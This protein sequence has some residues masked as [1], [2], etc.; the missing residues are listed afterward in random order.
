MWKA[1]CSTDSVQR[2][3]GHNEWK[4]ES[5]T[6]QRSGLL[7]LDSDLDVTV[8]RIAVGTA[9]QGPSGARREPAADQEMFIPECLHDRTKPAA[10]V[11]DFWS[12]PGKQCHQSAGTGGGAEKMRQCVGPLRE[13]DGFDS[14]LIQQ[15]PALENIHGRGIEPRSEIYELS[16][17]IGGLPLDNSSRSFAGEPGCVK[18]IIIGQ[19]AD[20]RGPFECR[21]SGFD[22]AAGGIVEGKQPGGLICAKQQVRETFGAVKEG[23]YGQ[24][25]RGRHQ[26]KLS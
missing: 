23:T 9:E 4:C 7:R 20:G 24:R 10:Q 19:E 1:K 18:Q 5:T 16:P 14:R 13:F 17:S 22:R 8:G 15:H 3:L 11:P 2:A 6:A 25:P 12:P 21:E 26:S